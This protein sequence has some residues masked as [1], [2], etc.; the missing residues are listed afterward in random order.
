MTDDFEAMLGSTADSSPPRGYTASGKKL[1]RPSREERARR[2]TERADDLNHQNEIRLAGS[3]HTKVN[4][5]EFFLPVSVNFLARVLRMDPMTV[6]ARLRALKPVGTVGS[7]RHVYYFHD[8]L[9]YLI[10][11]KMTADQFAKTLNKADLPPEINKSFWDSQRSRVKYKIEAQEAWETE[12]VLKV[13]GD[14]A[15]MIKDSLVMVVEE[16]RNRAKLDEHQTR[17][18]TETIDEIRTEM[19]AQLVD[20]PARRATGSMFAKPLFGVSGSIDGQP[21]VPE[22][23]W[24]DD[25]DDE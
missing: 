20:L 23:G 4:E 1:G 17:I 8:A 3:G 18:V 5:D 9:P 14:V 6:K 7:G 11:P 13:L 24:L 10:K 2:A 12:D 25:E 22:T 19:R 15:M 21:D 16:L